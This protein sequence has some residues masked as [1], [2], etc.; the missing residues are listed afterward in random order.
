M[1]TNYGKK[2]SDFN[3]PQTLPLDLCVPVFLGGKN[4]QISL[5]D[6]RALVTLSYLGL[7]NVNNTSDLE[8]PISLAVKEA[9]L[10]KAES[11]HVHAFGEITGL[12]E[13]LVL[14]ASNHTHGITAIDG[15][16][17]A[18]DAKSD[19]TH[20]HSYGEITGLVDVLKAK[21]ERVH[22][23]SLSDVNGLPESIQNLWSVLNNKAASEHTHL[24]SDISDLANVVATQVAAAVS[25][26][27]VVDVGVMEW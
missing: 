27:A 2:L 23:H 1:A 7:D 16:Q 6:I 22:G 25:E 18:L 11:G 19:K 5:A 21:A 4:Y 10:G 14:N 24:A 12:Q 13:Y 20:G 15:L 8:K 3:A 9:L 17:L 26:Q